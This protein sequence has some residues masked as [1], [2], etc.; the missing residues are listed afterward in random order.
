VSAYA[1]SS[2][3]TERPAGGASR[4]QYLGRWRPI[5]QVKKLMRPNLSDVAAEK[6]R[7]GIIE[8][9][10]PTRARIY[11]DSGDNFNAGIRETARQT[12]D[13]TK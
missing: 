4:K 11:I 13:A 8:F 12:S 7:R 3:L 2:L 9:I 1:S 6:G 5:E 10:C